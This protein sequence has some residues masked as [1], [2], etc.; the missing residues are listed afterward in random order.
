MLD[1][2][3]AEAVREDLARQRRDCDLQ[4]V[5]E[6]A[7]LLVCNCGEAHSCALSLEDVAEVFEVGVATAHDAV[8]ELEGR[9]VGAGVDFVGS[10]HCAGGGAVGLGV[11]DLGWCQ[12]CLS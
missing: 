3:V 10:V 6:Y 12:P 11:L 4:N 7:C 1:H 5:Y 8:A 2:I 9:N